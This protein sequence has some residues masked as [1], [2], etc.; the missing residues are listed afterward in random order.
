[1]ADTYERSQQLLE[2]LRRR[3]TERIALAS[4]TIALV[5]GRRT[6]KAT[7]LFHGLS[8]S[9]MQFAAIALTLHQGGHNVL[10]PRLPKHGHAD[11]MSDALARLTAADLRGI[12]TQSLEIARG[13]G[14]R[15]TIAGLSLGGLLAAWLA[16]NESFD[17]AVP[18]A[19][20]MGLALLPD[21]LAPRVMRWALAGPNFFAWWNPLKRR[22]QPP[23]HGYPRFATHSLAQAYE[24]SLELANAAAERP[25][26][27]KQIVVVTNSH[28]AALN[29][30]AIRKL[31]AS[32]KERRE[33][34]I[35]TY[36]F[37]DLPISH[38]IVEPRGDPRIIARVYP[39][40]LK[41]LE[42]A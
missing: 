18:I 14:E 35:E 8:T 7:V 5:H 6:E 38:D 15:V 40:L 17:R 27:A 20:Y 3:D 28:E 24:I 30:R 4:R 9:P 12:A 31:V 10:V 13:L 11:R 21:R 19:P 36:E 2:Q 41:I 39:T 32:W 34:G 42:G 33:S 22:R 26:A 29:N 16:Q 37:S 23:A 25:A 1:M